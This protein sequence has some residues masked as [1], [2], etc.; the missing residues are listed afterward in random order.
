MEYLKKA[1]SPAPI[2]IGFGTGLWMTPL[3]STR[4]SA[5]KTSCNTSIVLTLPSGSKWED[6]KEDGS[7]PFLDIIVKPEADGSLSITMYRKPT[8][9]DSTYSGI[10]IIT[11]QPNSVLTIPSPIG[12]KQCAPGLNCSNKKWT[13]LGRLSLNAN[14]LNGLW[15]GGEKT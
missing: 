2:P 12:P 13:T 7:I 1:L 6:N 3:S 9:T 15:E 8:H 4:R 10:A 5:N 11:S 14:I